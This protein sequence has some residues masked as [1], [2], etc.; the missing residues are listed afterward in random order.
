MPGEGGKQTLFL[1]L[2]VTHAQDVRSLD[3]V[4][5]KNR[6]RPNSRLPEGI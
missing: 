2:G 5:M 6:K 3:T 4:Q 1:A